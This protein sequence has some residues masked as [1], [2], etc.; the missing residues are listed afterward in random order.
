M[1]KQIGILF[2]LSVLLHGCLGDNVDGPT[3]VP[4]LVF[5]PGNA[6]FKAITSTTDVQIRWNRSVSDTQQNFKGYFVKL[7]S[8]MIDTSN[9]LAEDKPITELDSV[10]VGPGDTSYTFH[11]L[12]LLQRY[13]VRIY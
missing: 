4:R 2:L 3:V 1:K 9:L 7:Y 5:P 13:T 12:S 11:N 8:S 6:Y 10:H